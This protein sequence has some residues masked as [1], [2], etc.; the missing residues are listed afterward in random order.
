MLVSETNRVNDEPKGT[1]R[2]T[3]VLKNYPGNFPWGMRKTTNIL[4]FWPRSEPGSSPV[5]AKNDSATATCCH[6][7]MLTCIP[8]FDRDHFCTTVGPWFTN[9]RTVSRITNTQAGNSGKLRVQR[10]SQLLVNF[11]SVHIPAWF[12]FTKILIHEWPPGTY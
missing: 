6:S 3:S 8:S 12:R 7:G 1:W 4:K 9:K 10:G 2:E 5:W 11:G